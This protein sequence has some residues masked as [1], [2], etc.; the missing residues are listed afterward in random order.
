[1]DKQF[2]RVIK[3]LKEMDQYENTMILFVSDHGDMLGE[4]NRFSKY[5]MYESSI[6]IPMIISGK[7][8]PS[9]MK[10]TRS[11][12]LVSLIDIMPTLVSAA[13]GEVPVEAQAGISLDPL[14]KGV[15]FAK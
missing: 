9:R 10:G 11:Q 3:K 14:K 7:A 8:V 5:C 1:V 15:Y 6:R 12:Q 13:E 4:R 2:G